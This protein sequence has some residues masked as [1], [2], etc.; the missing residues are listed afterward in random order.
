[1]SRIET[2]IEDICRKWLKDPITE[3]RIQHDVRGPLCLFLYTDW[4]NEKGKE[5]CYSLP[6][7]PW[8]WKNWSIEQIVKHLESELSK[9]RDELLSFLTEGGFKKC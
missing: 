1:M 5:G 3:V 4:Q 7:K 6:L 9:A 8:E 2:P